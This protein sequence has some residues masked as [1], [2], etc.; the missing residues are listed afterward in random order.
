MSEKEGIT[1]ISKSSSNTFNFEQAD[2]KVTGYTHS[3]SPVKDE[4]GNYDYKNPKTIDENSSDCFSKKVEYEYEGQSKEKYYVKI[5]TDGFIF[6][7]WGMFSAGTQ[8][9]YAKSKG[10]AE[11]KFKQV[12]ERCFNFYNKFLQSRNSA[13]LTNAEREI[14]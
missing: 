12:N 10:R 2:K 5:G 11:W 8:A 9:R 4:D 13:W 3:S 1:S 6:N 7:P 14:S